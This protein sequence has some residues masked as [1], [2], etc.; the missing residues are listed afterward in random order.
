MVLTYIL[1]RGFV[2]LEPGSVTIQSILDDTDGKTNFKNLLSNVL[3]R[4]GVLYMLEKVWG[5]YND[6]VLNFNYEREP[7]TYTRIEQFVRS[8]PIFTGDQW[9]QT[10]LKLTPTLDS[11]G[12]V[13]LTEVQTERQLK[14][15]IV[16]GNTLLAAQWKKRAHYLICALEQSTTLETFRGAL[17]Q[18]G[19][20]YKHI[21]YTNNPYLYRRIYDSYQKYSGTTAKTYIENLSFVYFQTERIF[22]QLLRG[23]SSDTDESFFKTLDALPGKC[24]M[25]LPAFDIGTSVTILET[26]AGTGMGTNMNRQSIIPPIPN[27][28]PIPSLRSVDKP[29][30]KVPKLVPGL[31]DDAVPFT[32]LD[33]KAEQK[34]FR[35][36]MWVVV[37]LGLMLWVVFIY[38]LYI[39]TPPVSEMEYQP[40][41][42][43]AAAS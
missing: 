1:F 22:N 7:L 16:P 41:V 42:V 40:I 38:I 13:Y 37:G 20:E 39:Y 30:I 35:W 4:D 15:T 10:F 31:P 24:Q 43:P 26:P 17:L 6:W 27:L 32:P 5:S 8:H 2:L 34:I 19:F 21:L 9:N 36:I 28:I 18:Y 12:S 11:I 14:Q 33:T 29:V 23:G 25:S 3:D